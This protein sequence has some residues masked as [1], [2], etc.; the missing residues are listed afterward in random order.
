MELALSLV[1]AISPFALSERSIHGEEEMKKQ[2]GFTLI[3][4]MIVVAIIGILA[5]IAI[6][7]YQDYTIRAQVRRLQAFVQALG[8]ESFH[9]GGSSMGGNIADAHYL[10]R[11]GQ[12]AARIR[13]QHSWSGDAEFP[14][15]GHDIRGAFA[16]DRDARCHRQIVSTISWP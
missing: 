14:D 16:H 4:L 8:I 15:R 7:A 11:S 1:Q 13:R 6:P 3:E 10:G 5:A 2:Q 9:L 12:G